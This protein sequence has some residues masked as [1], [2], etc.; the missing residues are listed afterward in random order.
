MGSQ[1]SLGDSERLLGGARLHWEAS[2][3]TGRPLVLSR[4]QCGVLGGR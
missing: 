2:G 3:C 1:N 4:V